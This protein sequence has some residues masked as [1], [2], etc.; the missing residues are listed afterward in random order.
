MSHSGTAPLRRVPLDLPDDHR[1]L[2]RG[3]FGDALADLA[4]PGRIR[5]QTLTRATTYGR[6]IDAL[7]RGEIA[8]PDEAARAAVEEIADED[9]TAN[10]RVAVAAAALGGLLARLGDVGAEVAA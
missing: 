1:R 2:L 3:V 8:V 5:E 10:D 9:R 4:G 7:D 6:L